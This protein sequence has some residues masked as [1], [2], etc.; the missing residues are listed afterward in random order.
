MLH[1]C[2][3]YQFVLW[4]QRQIVL[5]KLLPSHIK[6]RIAVDAEQ[7][8]S[9]G[10][11]VLSGLE[12]GLLMCPRPREELRPKIREGQL[13]HLHQILYMI[14]RNA[15]WIRRQISTSFLNWYLLKSDIASRSVFTKLTSSV[16][17]VACLG[18]WQSFS[19]GAVILLLR[20]SYNTDV[21][22]LIALYYY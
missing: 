3:C 9:N 13:I 1:F 2:L 4:F 7:V 6:I 10:P 22:S 19:T 21:W 14:W 11:A 8:S 18:A 20:S 17:L 12:P 5:N 15:T 16:M